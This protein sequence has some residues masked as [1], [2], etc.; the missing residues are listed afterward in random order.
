MRATF[1]RVL[2]YGVLL[3][4]DVRWAGIRAPT[5]HQY[6]STR[7]AMAAPSETPLCHRIRYLTHRALLSSLN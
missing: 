6:P 1:G 4:A 2:V 3:I 7:S 5:A